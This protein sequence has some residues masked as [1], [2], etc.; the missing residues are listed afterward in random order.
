VLVQQYLFGNTWAPSEERE[1]HRDALA[2]RLRAARL[3]W[4]RELRLL[5]SRPVKTAL[6]LT[7]TKIDACVAVHELERRLRGDSLRQVILTD[8]IR[9]E[10][11]ADAE[12]EAVDLGAWP[13]FEAMA[14]AAEGDEAGRIGL[15][16]G[17][18]ALL[19]GDRLDELRVAL[20]GDAGALDAKPLERCPG[21]MRV[22]A[23]SGNRLV[24]AFTQLLIAGRLR[25]LVGTRALLGEGW[26][27]PAVNSLV[28]ASYVGTY[29]LTN[30]MR[31]RAI[32][33]DPAQPD[34]AASIWHLV[35]VDTSTEAGRADLDDLRGRFRTFVGLCA[36]R[37]V[38]ES[39]L[40]R[41]DLPE[42]DGPER[43]RELNEIMAERV[44]RHGTL[45]ERW[46][47][48]IAVSEE[49]R[50]LPSVRVA[51]P[52]QAR[53]FLL[54]NTL[55]HLL[56]VATS[57]FTGIFSWI[58]QSAR[59]DSGRAMLWVLIVAAVVA[60]VVSLPKFVKAL[61]LLIRHLPVDGSVRQIALAL[62]DALCEA[63]LL[64]TGRQDLAVKVTQLEDRSCSIA[65]AGG[66]FHE[67]ALFADSLEELLGA[68]ENPRYLLT[69]PGTGWW[70]WRVDYH[71]V[72][73]VLGGKKEK[74]VL[75]HMAWRR[76]LG[77][78]K[79]I[80]TR[81]AEGR[82]VLLKARGR[83]FSSAFASGA[84]RYDRWH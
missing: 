54:T 35:A 5:A 73:S 68:I 69:R 22:R 29:M 7:R 43:L 17:R 63:D 23:G 31:G 1:A 51:T 82:A 46:S 27:A 34:K 70:R 36:N 55:K 74:A 10:G 12:A 44:A 3:L 65:L 25:V 32:R 40:A 33:V 53:P 52:P 64:K 15:L 61:V 38:V 56:W 28:L 18:V 75:M 13:V 19:H 67:C 4:R 57:T 66:T 59:P 39:G 79:L 2:R 81:T 20:G 30:Q 60:T 11:L 76:R 58:V 24:R 80:Y 71:A 47:Q 37:P 48:A 84:Q 49:K 26:D 45:G 42:L 21:F 8:F 50:I 77:P 83:A 72:P 6:S 62:R 16:T 78:A 9:D 14:N 41:L